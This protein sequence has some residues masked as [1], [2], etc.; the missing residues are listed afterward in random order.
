MVNKVQHDYHDRRRKKLLIRR[1]VIVVVCVVIVVA[2][3]GIVLVINKLVQPHGGG[4]VASV[5]GGSVSASQT[6]SVSSE[7]ESSS[8][9]G[10]I[11][12][13]AAVEGKDGKIAAGDNL[14]GYE[15]LYPDLYAPMPLNGGKLEVPESKTVYL[16]FDDGP[17]VLTQPLLDV[18]DQY[19]AKVTFFDTAQPL[20]NGYQDLMKTCVEKGHAVGIHSYSHIYAN[21]Y[22]SVEAYLDDFNQM[23]EKIKSVTG[24]AP[25]IF[26]FPGGSDGGGK[27]NETREK[28][29]KEMIRRGFIYYD[30][31]G[32]SGDANT[33]IA[34]NADTLYTNIMKAIHKDCNIILMHNIN[35]K[36]ATIEAL[37]RAIP[38]AQG[39]GYTFKALDGTL[40]PTHGYC[41]HET[42]PIL[43]KA[44]DDSPYF[45]VSDESKK[46]F[47]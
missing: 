32:S 46:K 44:L 40:D 8:S 31:D 1:T 29:I 39:E 6:E 34:Q 33:D 13:A 11:Q 27:V 16:T 12:T 10:A 28:I 26:R 14:T 18:L 25:R 24:V 15:A 2:V 36:D 7:A 3:V 43:M 42:L 30:W 22:S 4:S 38:E 21:I 23:Y 17:S 41:M 47:G 35:G 19:Q 5:D 45:T 20:T 37:K 9:D